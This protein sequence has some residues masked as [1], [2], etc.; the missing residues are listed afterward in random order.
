MMPRVF[1]ENG[2][3]TTVYDAPFA[4]YIWEGDMSIYDPYP[5]IHGYRLKEQ[6]IEPESFE[7][8]QRLRQRQFF[9]YGLYKIFPL[10]VDSNLYDEGWYLYPDTFDEPDMQFNDNYAILEHLIALTDVTD[11]K[12]NTFMMMA[13]DITH[14]PNQLQLPDYTP[15]VHLDNERLETGYRTDMAGNKIQLDEQ[16]HYHVFMAALLKIGDWLD[17]LKQEGVYDNTRIIIAS[18]HGQPL[19]QFDSLILDDGMDAEQLAVLLMYKDFG[20]TMYSASFDFMTNADCPTLAMQNLI[21]DPI[22]PFTGTPIDES[23]KYAHDTY[24]C[25]RPLEGKFEHDTS[26]QS[27]YAVHD[28][29]YDSSNWS[30][31]DDPTK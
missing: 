23:I 22:N 10:A 24:I 19:G 29:I 11:D 2:F 5:D 17:Y 3:R 30:K 31:I 28:N 27:W 8:T 26:G 9:M 21:S 14:S 16:Y 13:N 18:D 15:S 7:L 25:P 6:F 12:T 4:N 20:E 1:S